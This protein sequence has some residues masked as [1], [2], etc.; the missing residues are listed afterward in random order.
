MPSELTML[1]LLGVLLKIMKCVTP[2]GP[3]MAT[4]SFNTFFFLIWCKIKEAQTVSGIVNVEQDN[5]AHTH[6]DGLQ[7][8][9]G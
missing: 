1:R 3:A 4:K 7:N 9:A 6:K 8:A 2:S 5:K